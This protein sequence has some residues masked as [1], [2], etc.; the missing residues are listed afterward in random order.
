MKK[1]SSKT[2]YFR[3][4][5]I[6]IILLINVLVLFFGFIFFDLAFK[7]LTLILFPTLIFLFVWLFKFRRLEVVYLGN[8]YLEINDEKILF[9][10]II[11]INK[12]SSFCYK[13]TYKIDNTI[14]SII[15]M[16]DSF[17]TY[18]TSIPD[19]VKEIREFIE[20]K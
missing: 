18:P 16:V 6:P 12:I 19:F 14:K 3:K 10:D 17:P 5:I 15:F 13:L 4:K 11:S 2:T 7:K 8:K 1:I 20:K 9:E